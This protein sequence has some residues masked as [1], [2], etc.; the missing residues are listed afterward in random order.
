MKMEF[1]QIMYRIVYFASFIALIAGL[2]I[3]MEYAILG[4][5]SMVY[6]EVAWK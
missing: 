5:S 2:F 3:R 4:V 6:A 1:K